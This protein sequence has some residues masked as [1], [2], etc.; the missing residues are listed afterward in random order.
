M[1]KL[2]IPPEA[3]GKRL[4]DY[5]RE[6]AGSTGFYPA[7]PCGGHGLCGKCRVM[8]EDGRTLLACRTLCPPEG[9]VLLVPEES[10]AAD[11]APGAALPPGT[12]LALDI[13]TTT[14][15]LAWAEPASGRILRERTL[16]NPQQ[17]FGAD[18]LSR[19][20]ASETQLDGLTE[21][22]RGALRDAMDGLP[23]V[24]RIIAVGNPTMLSLF[25]GVSP[26][27]MG[28]APF[29]P[30]FTE[31][32]TL[33]GPALGLPASEVRLLPGISAY[34]GA[35]LCAGLAAEGI[36]GKTS[37][38]LYLD[39]GTNAEMA[40]WDPGRGR[41]TVTSAA[42]GPALEGARISCGMGGVIGAVSR[43]FVR[44]GLFF[45]ET[46]GDA[47]ARGLCGSGLV[48]LCACLLEEGLLTESGYLE[49]DFELR[50][51]HHRADGDFPDASP[52][53]V[54]TRQ[55]VR[56]LQLAKSAVYTGAE[57]LLEEA[58]LSPG[59]LGEVLLAGGLGIFIDPKSAVRI[60]L[61][62]RAFLK[63]LRSCG[64][65]ALRGAV[66]AMREPSA[67]VREAAMAETLPLSGLPSFFDLFLENMSFPEH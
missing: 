67:G 65:A 13:G 40:L 33:S 12:E 55:D 38:V 58:G 25:S 47:P 42:A 5:L 43:V 9:L 14:L 66:L 8:T 56:E 36:L 35:D 19:I 34:A 21:A 18:V 6:Q 26:L 54:L 64:N 11:G 59:E 61:L 52:V 20:T 44:R 41:L 46:V 51:V 24:P 29:T 62:P 63:K 28:R 31:A 50:G 1:K 23:P 49:E 27:P 30:A 32:Q 39:L 10:L 45:Y 53:L 15:A 4:S 48:D 17:A 3:C 60:G 22:V 2:I 16:L 37:P 57:L 7:Q